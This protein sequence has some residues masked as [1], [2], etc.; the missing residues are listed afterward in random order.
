MVIAGT[1]GR[2]VRRYSKPKQYEPAA[3]FR[4]HD[5]IPQLTE[6]LQCGPEIQTVRPIAFQTNESM[7]THWLTRC[8]FLTESLGGIRTCNMSR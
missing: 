6:I 8:C 5:G 2:D 7:W 4:S 1:A 3:V